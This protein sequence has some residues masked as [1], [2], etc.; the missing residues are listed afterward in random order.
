MIV[1]VPDGIRTEQ[2]PNT[3][4]EPYFY[5]DQLDEIVID[6]NHRCNYAETTADN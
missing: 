6:D 2:L 3:T 1:G 4:L 5:S